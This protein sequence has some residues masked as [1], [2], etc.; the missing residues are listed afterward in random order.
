[1]VDVTETKITLKTKRTA[2]KTAAKEGRESGEDDECSGRPQTYPAAEHNEKF[3]S[4]VRTFSRGYK[5]PSD[6]QVCNKPLE[7]NEVRR[8]LQAYMDTT[9]THSP[10]NASGDRQTK[11][12]GYGERA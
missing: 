6:P 2:R 7:Q 4:P 5:V 9:A 11:V 12:S 3:S 8:L 1:M 10:T